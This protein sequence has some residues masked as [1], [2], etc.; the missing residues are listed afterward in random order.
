MVRRLALFT[1]C[2]T[3]VLTQSGCSYFFGKDGVFPDRSNDYLKSQET[4]RITLPQGVHEDAIE[5][6]Y[7]IPPIADSDDLGKVF[8]TPRPAPLASGVD[9]DMVRIQ[10]L[11][12]DSWAIIEL[13]PGQ[14]WPRLREFLMS[15]GI[16]PEF[17]DGVAG[18]LET[19][20]LLRSEDAAKREK[21]RFTVLQGVQRESS[22]VRVLQWE[23]DRDSALSRA[24][25]PT[26]STV[27]ERENWMLHEFST[28]VANTSAAD[29]VSLLAQ[30]IDTK[31]RLK[32]YRGEDSHILVDLD[33][34]RAWASTAKALK[35]AQFNI[36]D[37]NR[38]SGE[39]FARYQPAELEEDKPGFF[40]RM[41]GASDEELEA[42]KGA[43]YR[44]TVSNSTERKGWSEVRLAIED[45]KGE[46][47]T[48]EQLENLLIEIKGQLS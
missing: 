11:K 14:V 33:R 27:A 8:E 42:E 22:E 34:N 16:T 48:A 10:S 29:S 24:D 13:Q 6:A 39:F 44:I 41:F 12:G 17:S 3:I 25:W 31:G 9:E 47:I 15:N 35:K 1:A 30:G 5:D 37:L 43:L 45:S 26:T 18:I 38:D 7:V 40:A 4:A 36:I 32:L 2:T 28:F 20:W 21:F 46:E 19:P 23:S